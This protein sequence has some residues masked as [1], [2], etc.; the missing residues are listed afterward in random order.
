MLQFFC[1]L[2]ME[3]NPDRTP[4]IRPMLCEKA[5]QLLSRVRLN[6]SSRMGMGGGERNSIG[7]DW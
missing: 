6:T 3:G 2:N 7:F 4:V 5:V 1:G